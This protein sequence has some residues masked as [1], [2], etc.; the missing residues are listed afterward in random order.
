[1]CLVSF[2]YMHTFLPNG[3][4][5]RGEREE[6]VRRERRW[7]RGGER[8]KEGELFPSRLYRYFSSLVF[9]YTPT[10]CLDTNIRKLNWF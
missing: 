5:K 9:L 3:F 4:S 10:K 7:R 8:R 6:K 1:M 2:Y